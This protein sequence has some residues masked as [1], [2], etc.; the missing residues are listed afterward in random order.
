M[1]DHICLVS[2]FYDVIIRYGHNIALLCVP[3][4]W[5]AI[6]YNEDDLAGEV[7]KL[8]HAILVPVTRRGL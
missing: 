3:I 7:G 2:M 8:V 4:T 6:A 5:Y 1:C